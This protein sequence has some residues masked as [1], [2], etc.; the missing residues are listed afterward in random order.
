[1]LTGDQEWALRRLHKRQNQWRWFR[2]VALVGSIG[3]VVAG[4]HLELSSTRAIAEITSVPGKG[5]DKPATGFDLFIAATHIKAITLAELFR[6]VGLGTIVLVIWS[7]RG[8]PVDI[9]LIK[10]FEPTGEQ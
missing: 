5:F 9:L 7:W 4:L 8:R 3:L 6:A 1:M 10:A 2:W